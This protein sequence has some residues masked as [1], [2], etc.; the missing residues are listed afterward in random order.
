MKRDLSGEEHRANPPGSPICP[1]GGNALSLGACD[2]VH[3]SR[4]GPSEDMELGPGRAHLVK[5]E[6]FQRNSLQTSQDTLSI[7]TWIHVK[8][9]PCDSPAMESRKVAHLI[10]DF[11]VGV[12]V[13]PEFVD[14]SSSLVEEKQKKLVSCSKCSQ[15][16]YLEVF[17]PHMTRNACQEADKFS[18]V[19]SNHTCKICTETI[20]SIQGSERPHKYSITKGHFNQHK[21]IHKCSFCSKTFAFMLQLRIHQRIHLCEK[22]YKCSHCVKAFRSSSHLQ[23]HQRTHT[24]EKPYKCSLC[25]K[26][27]ARS[28][29]LNLHQRT[30]T[31]EKPY[32]CSVC[33]KA[34][35]SS[36]HLHEH[37]RTHTGEKPYKCSLCMKAFAYSAGFNVHRRT[38]TGEKPYKCTLCPKAYT[39]STRLTKHQR[40]HTNEKGDDDQPVKPYN[41][42]LCNRD[43]AFISQLK[44]HERTH[45]GEKPYECSICMKAFA[46]SSHLDIHQRTHTGEKPYK[47]SLCMK[48]FARSSCLNVH[49]RT[50]TGEKPY[51]CTLCPKAFPQSSHL[52]IH[53]RLHMNA[54]GD[55]EQ[56]E[57][58]HI[59]SLCNK[60]FAFLSQLKIHERTHTGEKPYQ[61][62]LCIK[63]FTRP[64]YLNVHQRKHTGD[65]I[66]KDHTQKLQVSTN[67]L[68]PSLDRLEKSLATVLHCIV[69]Y[70]EILC[71]T[72]LHCTALP[73]LYVMKRDLSGEEHRANPP[74]SPICPDGG[75]ALI[76]G[77]CDGVHGSRVGPSEDMEL[78]PDF[79]VEVKVESDSVDDYSFI[80]KGRAHVVKSETFQ[81]NFLQTSQDTLS[82][83]PWVHVKQEPCDSPSKNSS[84]V[85]H[86]I[87]D[88]IV[89]VK[90]EPEFVDDYSSIVEA[91]K[92][93]QEARDSPPREPSKAAQQ[94]EEKQKKLVS[95][96]KCS[97]L[98][99]LEVFNPHMT[100][101]ACQEADKFTTSSNRTCKSCAE[102]L[103]GI[104]GSERP[105]K[106]DI[107]N[108]DNKQREKPHIC[109]FCSKDFAFI[110]QLKIHERTHTGEKPYKCSICMKAFA[111]SSYLN[112][113]QRAHMGETPYK[114]SFCSKD[115]PFMSQLK[116][117][118]RTHTGEKPY[119]CSI[120]MKG[121][122]SSSNLDVHQM[123]HTGEKP[124]KCSS[125]RKEFPFIS[126]LKIHQRIHTGEKPYKCSICMKAFGSSSNLDI[127]QITH[128]D[129]KLHCCSVC[130]KTFS[131]L[132]TL[133]QHEQIHTGDKPHKCS[134]CSK[135]FTRSSQLHQH[136]RIHTRDKPCKCSVC[137]KTFTDSSTLRQHERIHTGEKPYK[138]SVC[139]K[140]VGE[141]HG[142]IFENG[143]QN[144]GQ[145]P[146]KPQQKMF[147]LRD[148]LVPKFLHGMRNLELSDS[149][150]IKAVLEMPLG[151]EVRTRNSA[152]LHYG[153]VQPR[154]RTRVDTINA[155]LLHE[156]V[157][158]LELKE[159]SRA[160]EPNS[161]TGARATTGGASSWVRTGLRSARTVGDT[162]E[163]MLDGRRCPF[164]A[165]VLRVHRRWQE[166]GLKVIEHCAKWIDYIQAAG[167]GFP[168]SDK[169]CKN[170]P[171]T[172][173][174]N[175][176]P[177]RRRVIP[178]R[179]VPQAFCGVEQHE[180]PTQDWK[181]VRLCN[182]CTVR[183][184]EVLVLYVMKRDLS[185]EEHRANLPGS[186]I[187]PD[188]GNALSP[189]ACDGVHGSRVG[190]SEDMELGP[191]CFTHVV[192]SETFQRNL[193]QTS[194]NTLRM[195]PWIHVKQEPCDSPSRESSKVAHLIEDFIMEVKVESEFIDDYS[196]LVKGEAHLVKSK[197]F[198]SSF[199]QTS[200]D[201]LSN[202]HVKQEARDSPPRENS[203]AA[204]LL[205]E[206]QK[207]LVSCSKCSQLFDLE[208]F[209]PHMTRNARQETDKFSS[210]SS[211]HTCK[212][213]TE[214]IKSIQ[215]SQRLHRY[216]IAD[217]V[218]NQ[219]KK[220]HKCSICS[221]GFPFMSHFKM[222]QRTHTGDKPYK[223][224]LCM[225]V[226]TRSSHLDEHQKI[227]T[228][229]KPYKC[230]ICMKG[231][232]RSSY[233]EVHQRTHTGEKPYKCTLCPKAFP[234]STRLTRHQKMHTNANGD[235]DQP[236]KPCKCSLCSKTFDF[237]SQLKVHE[238]THTGEKPYKCSVCSKVFA[239][240]SHL[241]VHQRT[242]TGEKP[243]KCSVCSKVLAYSSHL[244]VHHRTHTGEKP[245]KCSLCKKAFTRSSYLDVHQRT[246]TGEKP[247]KCALCPKTFPQSSHLNIHQRMHTSANGD[248]EQPEKTH[249]CSLCNKAFTFMSQLKV[250]ERTHT[251]VKPY[252]CSLCM[253]AFARSSHLYVHQRTHTG[254]K[255]NADTTSLGRKD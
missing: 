61:C 7:D 184:C 144:I 154:S 185:G 147:I 183:Y 69:R 104:Q 32:K 217:G 136:E 112:V 156:A 221:K 81:R 182:K 72:V 230:S 138:C 41:C 151:D 180:G 227:H 202:E 20:K 109:S 132:S 153:G 100:R 135:T 19:S 191:G 27:F 216:N 197:K 1:D 121:F 74:G 175:K 210:V 240:S 3:G 204:P 143:L 125:C 31:G 127:H 218:Y 171:K 157:D 4:V 251:G 18:T 123:A 102:T 96:S 113:H 34:F 141:S 248:Y 70:C 15:L 2:G 59:C 228:G 150:Y 84:K 226:F 76:P 166:K 108:G 224:S 21:K 155:R 250:H 17:N 169:P 181:R 165:D 42:S 64:S 189:G 82:I 98:F 14:D 65:M 177:S 101:N 62:S 38:H 163:G 199:L 140:G 243:Y 106:Y 254:E 55:Y 255:Y 211:N 232:I 56:P 43:F 24:G 25:M 60:A 128:T 92:P 90:V 220:T 179:G 30:H 54:N 118:E 29:C 46:R 89:E 158:G 16:F 57:K 86:L 85:A 213:C 130:S 159:A 49:Q 105:H 67:Q 12:K 215:G 223:C 115:F 190:P 95:C 79:I 35:S 37:Q 174:A 219:R 53:R 122:G 40:L 236:E 83:H 233:L 28:S 10:E 80:N 200:Q 133:H 249:K 231:F 244:D 178:R 239:Y 242:H 145:A 87:E 205:E 212:S 162:L 193:L 253:K 129:E 152:V 134:V 78:G 26:A 33:M 51:K 237:M 44:I 93:K 214:T 234:Q 146:L 94:L 91:T 167:T 75:N 160:P 107:A 71:C 8:Q 247:Y 120:C 192:K 97:Q 66:N 241:E 52:N 229:E 73:V 39:Q 186:P 11:T 116:I 168:V 50:H 148:H 172:I 117:H 187:C 208:I 45:T 235:H 5:S 88:L 176:D 225:K 209:S 142:K 68:I 198:K 222:H 124:H 149:P 170:E 6:T 111:H 139:N 201:A 195:H 252:K 63:A 114:C 137:N 246:H 58:T 164:Q 47:C 206:K 188:G 131:R 161:P 110:S 119:K 23:E 36:S 9:E 196:S 77:A 203:K 103:K 173:I 22:P 48:A 13:E 207:K 126:Q 245:F 238:R 194:Q 99:D